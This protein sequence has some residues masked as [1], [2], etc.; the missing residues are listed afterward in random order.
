MET[1]EMKAQGLTE[2]EETRK[3]IETAYT[4]YKH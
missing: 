2:K 1:K 4:Q 3:G